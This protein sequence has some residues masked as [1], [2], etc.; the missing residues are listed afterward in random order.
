MLETGRGVILTT[1]YGSTNVLDGPPDYLYFRPSISVRC[2]RSP[3]AS[4][5]VFCRCADRDCG[6][7][8]GTKRRPSCHGCR[9]S[10]RTLYCLGHGRCPPRLY[11]VEGGRYTSNGLHAAQITAKVTWTCFSCTRPASILDPTTCPASNGSSPCA[12]PTAFSWTK[13]L[14]CLEYNIVE[15]G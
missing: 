3:A 13:S 8:A 4:L 10:V 1:A 14:A 5:T 12:F 7:S 9:Q 2:S 15:T 11:C 6:K